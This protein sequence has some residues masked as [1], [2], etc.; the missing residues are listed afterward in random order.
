MQISYDEQQ[1]PDGVSFI[2]QVMEVPIPFQLPCDF[3]GVFRYMANEYRDARA[4]RQ[5]ENNPASKA[6]SRRAAWRIIKNWVE[7][8]LAI[9]DA[10]QATMAQVFLPY[11]RMQEQGG[12]T[13]YAKFMQ[14]VAA[15][16]SLPPAERDA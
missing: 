15:Q 16:K 3:T 1:R 7:A 9:I 14:Q 2:I 6:Q 10:G 5:F 8:Q 4:R 12:I 11:V 13:M